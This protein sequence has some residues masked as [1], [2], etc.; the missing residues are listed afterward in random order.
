M[1]NTFKYLGIIATIL[2]IGFFMAA[3]DKD[4][5]EKSITISNIDTD[6]NGKFAFIT[7][8]SPTKTIA[9]AMGTISNGS[10]TNDLVDWANKKVWNKSGSYMVILL[11]YE[12][13]DAVSTKITLWEGGTTNDKSFTGE[14]TNIPFSQFI[15]TGPATRIRVVNSTSSETNIR[16]I[17]LYSSTSGNP[18]RDGDPYHIAD[19]DNMPLEPGERLTF[20]VPV[21]RNWAVKLEHEGGPTWYPKEEDESFTVNAGTAVLTIS[22]D[23]ISVSF[24]KE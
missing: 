14:T 11:I 1:K 22:G 9:Y 20:E 2:L 24:S 8:E 12:N 15:R 3:C 5:V 18:N 6:Y 19:S 10:F 4:E 17:S 23:P 7:L 13:I 21:G 16:N